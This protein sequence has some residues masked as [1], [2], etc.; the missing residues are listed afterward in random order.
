MNMRHIINLVEAVNR[1][2]QWYPDERGDGYLSWYLPVEGWSGSE[3]N[4]DRI[5]IF[6]DPEGNWYGHTEFDQNVKRDLEP[7]EIEQIRQEFDL[8]KGLQDYL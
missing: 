8:D 4:E 3:W 7:E 5:K 1:H 2:G 6:R